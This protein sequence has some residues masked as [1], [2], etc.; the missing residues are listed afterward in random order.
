MR[1]L[2]V[3]IPEELIRA[4]RRQG[5]DSFD[6]MWEGELHMAPLP[7]WRHQ[8]IDWD[9]VYFFRSH[10][11][12]LQEGLGCSHVGVKFP[13]TPE[14]DVA[15]Q[16]VPRS[17]RGPDLVFLLRGHEARVQEGWLVGPPDALIEIRSPGDE[18][19]E[20]FPFYFDLGVPELIVIHRDTKAVEIYTHGPNE[21]ERQ[22]PAPDGSVISKVLDTV[23][24][25]TAENPGGD[26]VLFL[27][28]GLHPERE[29]RA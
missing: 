16:S 11:E 18:T 4:R 12:N 10:W 1:A 3:D 20:K 7:S 9:L 13:G 5:I 25:T 22:V 24:R 2:Y 15:G 26:P 29:G 23:F 28:R 8:R 6:E 19:Y 14:V 17:F 27:R 21:F